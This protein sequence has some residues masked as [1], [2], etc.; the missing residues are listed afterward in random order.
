MVGEC[1]ASRRSLVLGAWCL[2]RPVVLGP[3]C[4]VRSE[5]YL[6]LGGN[7]TRL[8]DERGPRT[9]DPGPGTRPKD[10]PSTKAQGPRTDPLTGSLPV[11]VRHSR[12]CVLSVIALVP[13]P[14]HATCGVEQLPAPP[15]RIEAGDVRPQELHPVL[16]L[17]GR[18]CKRARERLRCRVDR[19]WIDQHG[20]PELSRRTGVRTPDEHDPL[21]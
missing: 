12:T 13:E 2:V 18:H 5:C 6:L 10:G 4:A 15:V 14:F 9:E 3:W 16:L 1:S 8:Q 11:V 17:G 19:I 20:C 7:S 21:V